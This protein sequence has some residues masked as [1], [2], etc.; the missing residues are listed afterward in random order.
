MRLGNQ[1]RRVL[2][3]GAWLAVAPVVALVVVGLWL[4]F[5]E[6][7]FARQE[8]REATEGA[9]LRLVKH[10]EEFFPLFRWLRG[11]PVDGDHL[12]VDGERGVL[13]VSINASGACLFPF[14]PHVPPLPDPK[15]LSWKDLNESQ[16]LLWQVATEGSDP[17]PRLQACDEV[18]ESEGPAWFTDLVA[19]QRIRLLSKLGR[20][21]EALSA[22]DLLRESTDGINVTET[23]M[24]FGVA[25]DLSVL[26]LLDEHSKRDE[27]WIARFGSVVSRQQR[28]PSPWTW[29]VLSKAQALKGI[30]QRENE[31]LGRVIRRLEGMEQARVFHSQLPQ[32]TWKEWARLPLG[33]AAWLD[34]DDGAR[35]VV[36]VPSGQGTGD[37]SLVIVSP[38]WVERT[39]RAEILRLGERDEALKRFGFG[40]TLANRSLEPSTDGDLGLSAI[41]DDRNLSSIT[42][43]TDVP[44]VQI[45]TWLEDPEL[46]FERSR[47][48]RNSMMG[49]VAFAGLTGL[50]GWWAQ[51][52]AYRQEVALGRMRSNFVA[53]VSHE[54]RAPVASI[55]LMSENLQAEGS[56]ST[57]QASESLAWIGV[58]CRRLSSL[59]EN[60][61]QF[62]RRESG[63]DESVFESV[64]VRRLFAESLRA[65]LPQAEN[66]GVRLEMTNET[67]E[68]LTREDLP[69]AVWDGQSIHLALVNLLDNAIKHSTV[70]GLVAF[71]LVWDT[72]RGRILF[73]VIDEGP[74]IPVEDRER[75]FQAFERLGSEETRRTKGVGVG[76][77]LVRQTAVAHHGSIRVFDA[78]V[79]GACFELELPIE[80]REV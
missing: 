35:L 14:L 49:L 61:L 9:A 59:V 70:G 2:E 29:W 71:G 65:M 44:W 77:A 67:S 3:W 1:G 25:L 58:E 41:P 5:Q 20:L 27:S 63:R 23:G 33:A 34:R 15:A 12:G 17:A 19:L 46:F 62:S 75:I 26:S 38:E 47:Q 53:S 24:P 66:V 56:T 8:A 43:F 76:L 22:V 16:I 40:F 21:D 80:V 13:L 32:T 69:D 68:Y 54:L 6:Q 30:G 10:L 52:K 31:W 79:K 73:R 57:T 45:Q 7:Q 4:I 42:R 78:P 36:R 50:L 37:V 74:G 51:R 72:R 11:E 60:V 64:D 39:L 18:L 48:R 28:D 55:R